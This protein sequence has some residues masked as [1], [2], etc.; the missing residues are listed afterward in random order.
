MK[1][2]SEAA[3]KKGHCE[4]KCE[5]PL[6]GRQSS[7]EYAW[8][9]EVW[10]CLKGLRHCILDAIYC[11]P[12]NN[13]PWKIN[14]GLKIC[15]KFVTFRRSGPKE[16][17]VQRLSFQSLLKFTINV[18]IPQVMYFIINIGQ[19]ITER[20]SFNSYL[21]RKD[22]KNYL[23]TVEVYLHNA[24]LDPFL[25]TVPKYRAAVDYTPRLRAPRN[26]P[27]CM[28]NSD[29]CDTVANSYPGSATANSYLGTTST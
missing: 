14:N 7:D 26:L 22:K 29:T 5:F 13:E 16:E 25:C 27:R 6:W 17:V 21:K 15:F 12:G 9:L 20:D 2:L 28:A 4:P 19:G 1:L 3:F 11:H 23:V 24:K 8:S 18:F 10:S